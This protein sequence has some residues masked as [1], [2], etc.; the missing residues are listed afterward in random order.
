M[1]GLRFAERRSHALLQALL[2]FRCHPNGFANKDLRTLTSELRGLDPAAVTVGQTTYDLRRLKSRD[3]I[4]RI[5]GTH[6]YQVTDHGLDTAKFLTTVHDRIL[7]TGLAEIHG[8]PAPTKLRVAAH[9]Y[10]TA[11][12]D[13]HPNSRARGLDGR[14]E[15][16]SIMPASPAQAS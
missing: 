4:T 2:T 15:L 11:I 13:P 5:P 8:P 7:P 14:T 9:A 10:E 6:R 3:L 1:P 12:N 16:D